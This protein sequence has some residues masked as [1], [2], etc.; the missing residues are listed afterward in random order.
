MNKDYLFV[1]PPSDALSL[2]V[3]HYKTKVAEIIGHYHGV[4]SK[5]HI[6]V[7]N[8]PNENPLEVKLALQTIKKRMSE[9][10]CI[11][12]GINGFNYFQHGDKMTIYTAIKGTYQID[13][14]FHALKRCFGK[15]TMTVPHITIIKSTSANHFYKLWPQFK[16]LTYQDTFIAD[17][18]LVLEKNTVQD[19]KGYREIDVIN[20]KN[21]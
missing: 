21:K 16:Q 9:L 20:F 7:H 8:I 2:Q 13:N 3:K 19:D 18:I 10:P 17:K 11:N 14:W 1:I 15:C 6:T 5:A 4:N 12:I